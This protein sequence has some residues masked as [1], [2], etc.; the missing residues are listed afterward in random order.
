[1]TYS[2]T[3]FVAAE[4]LF[5]AKEIVQIIKACGESGVTD[6]ELHGMNMKLKPKYVA[7]SE[8][9]SFQA[10]EQLTL[11]EVQEEDSF[12]NQAFTNPIEWQRQGLKG[13]V[14]NEE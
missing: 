10:P 11:T 3:D 9:A 5:T 4:Y 8:A 12:D 13:D 6:F 7:E 2:K 14:T 1:M